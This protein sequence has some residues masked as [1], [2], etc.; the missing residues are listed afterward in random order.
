MAGSSPSTRVTTCRRDSSAGRRWM[1]EGGSTRASRCRSSV[2]ST[3]RACCC[4]S[5]CSSC[6][7]CSCSTRRA[8]AV[9][10]RRRQLGILA[11]VGWTP[12]PVVRDGDDGAGPGGSGC[13]R[14]RMSRWRCPSRTPRHLHVSGCPSGLAVIAPSSWRCW[15]RW[16]RQEPPRELDRLEVLQPVAAGFARPAARSAACS[17]SRSGP[18]F[19]PAAAV[20]SRL[21]ASRSASPRPFS[22]WPSLRASTASSPAT[23][24]ARP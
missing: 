23:C 2:R 7:R 5:S 19:V 22:C 1:R 20:S 12:G 4:S 3:A 18:C 10:A 9:R 21:P 8:A 24:S 11:C 15:P 17:G 6:V 16:R 14:H 13:R